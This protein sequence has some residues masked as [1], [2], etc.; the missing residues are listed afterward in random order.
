MPFCSLS[1]VFYYRVIYTQYQLNRFRKVWIMFNRDGN[2]D[3]CAQSIERIK[4]LGAD[5]ILMNDV[6]LLPCVKAK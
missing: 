6:T 1:L 3:G 4:A 5:G 2:M